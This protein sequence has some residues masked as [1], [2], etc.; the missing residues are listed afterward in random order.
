MKLNPDKYEQ[1][2]LFACLTHKDQKVPGK[3]YAY[4]AHFTQVCIEVLTALNGAPVGN[5]DLAVQCALLHDVIEDTEIKY[6]EV[7]KEFG[8]DVARGVLALTKNKDL[9]K[10]QRM[11]D[12]LNRILKNPLEVGMVKMA[13]RIVNLQEPPHSWDQEK[14]AK[15]RKEAGLILE[16][17]QSCNAVLA[18]RLKMRIERYGKYLKQ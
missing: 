5:P 12:S 10:D 13:D 7:E 16:K 4:I 2:L 18:E 1:A 6:E 3:P 17:L 11:E 8:T 9:P 15:Y 14:I